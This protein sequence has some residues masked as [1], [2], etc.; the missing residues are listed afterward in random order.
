MV[1]ITYE[2]PDRWTPMAPESEIF[3]SNGWKRFVSHLRSKALN[4]CIEAPSKFYR[5]E[6]PTQK[7]EFARTSRRGLPAAGIGEGWEALIS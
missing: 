2:N 4:H 6:L 5:Y 1:E 3:P 7:Q